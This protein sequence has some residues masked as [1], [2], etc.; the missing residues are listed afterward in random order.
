MHGTMNIKL[1][2]I[3]L[4]WIFLQLFISLYISELLQY[5]NKYTYNNCI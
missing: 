3:V 2:I 1:N 4:N 5:Y